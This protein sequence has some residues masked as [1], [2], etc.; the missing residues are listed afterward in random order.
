MT[1]KAAKEVPV[2]NNPPDVQAK[3][4]EAKGLEW[5]TILS[6]HAARI[7]QGPEAEQVR[8]TMSHRIMG[9][10]FVM[11]IKQEEDALARMKAQWCLQGHLDPDF[12]PRK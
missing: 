1:K 6:K 8:R 5:N 9:S 4:D 7:V 3:V 2:S 10:R 12:Y 11:K